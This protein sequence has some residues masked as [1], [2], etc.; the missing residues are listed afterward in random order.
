MEI[1]RVGDKVLDKS[2]IHNSIEDILTRRSQGLSQQE[3]AKEL[4]LERTFISRLEGLGEIRKGARI[5]VIGFPVK[6]IEEIE[7]L[8]KRKGIEYSIILTEEGRWRFIK[9]KTGLEL[10][11]EIMGLLQKIR[12]FDKVVLMGSRQRVK[13]LAALIDKEVVTIEL[14]ESPL[15]E[16]IYVEIDQLERVLDYCQNNYWG[17]IRHEAS[18]K[19]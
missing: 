5:A 8:L 17:D 13:M 4:G 18:D 16:D 2:K 3:V 9:E 7:G 19:R 11:N 14:G 6:N 10:F 1:I 12:S 15:S